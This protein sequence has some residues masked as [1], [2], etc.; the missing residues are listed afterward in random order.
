MAWLDC[1]PPSWIVAEIASTYV[2]SLS[3]RESGETTLKEERCE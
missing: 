3:N 1:D 2:M